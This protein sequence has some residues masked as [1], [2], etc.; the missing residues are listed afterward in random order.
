MIKRKLFLAAILFGLTPLSFMSHVYA[1]GDGPSQ[2][3]AM[4]FEPVD[5]TDLVNLATG[6][7]TYN[8]PLLVV[9]G[10]A[11]DYAINLSYHAGIGPN[12]E[13]TW[14]GLGWTL[15]PGA[16]NRT[17]SGYPDDYNGDYVQT[18][19]EADPLSGWGIGI[20]V[21]YGPFGMNMSYDSHTGNAGVNY[22]VGFSF[23]IGN[24]AN[25]GLNVGTE[26]ITT[27][28]GAPM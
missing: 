23:S 27:R 21:G 4:Q 11:G 24:H 25:L 7:F 1:I 14:V 9:P 8:L 16:I 2:P 20:G 22:F 13:A 18:H 17:V 3:E 12:Q 26:G 15:N 19:Y 6:D 5:A 28:L 10:S